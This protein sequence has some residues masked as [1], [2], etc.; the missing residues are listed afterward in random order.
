M[1]HYLMYVS[2]MQQGIQ[3]RIHTVG[4]IQ[5]KLAVARQDLAEAAKEKKILEKLKEKQRERFLSEA[6]RYE[7]GQMDEMS[8]NRYLRGSRAASMAANG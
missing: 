4:E 1:G 5:K 6:E 7:R 8:T 2:H 3:K